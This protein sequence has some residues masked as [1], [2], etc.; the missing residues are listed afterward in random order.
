MTRAPRERVVEGSRTE[1][2]PDAES[3][4]IL[5]L[6][7]GFTAVALLLVG[8][9]TSAAEV[10][11]DRKHLADLAGVLAA[12]A[13][14][15]TAPEAFY[16]GSVPTP[17]DDAV[18]ALTDADVRGAVVGHLA[19]HPAVTTGLEDVAV[20][21]ASSRDGRSATVVLA[22]RSRPALLRWMGEIF[23]GGV[24][25]GATATARAW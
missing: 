7:V 21:E 6:A 1:T 8:A 11:L 14:D 17:S 4:R 2:R 18:L 20:V 25:L 15:A 24:P 13:A 3:G 23:P 9:V 19:R 16:T 5:V 12:D 22:A 10:H